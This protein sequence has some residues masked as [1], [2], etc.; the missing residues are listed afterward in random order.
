MTDYESDLPFELQ[1]LLD[2][3]LDK[4]DQVLRS[5]G[6][7]RTDRNAIVDEL[8]NQIMEMLTARTRD[9]GGG[10]G[11]EPSIDDLKA[12]LA[13]IDPPEAYGEESQ[14]LKEDRQESEPAGRWGRL[15]GMLWPVNAA[16]P[17]GL[18]LIS[19]VLVIAATLLADL[20]ESRDFWVLAFYFA[21][22]L[23]L[24]G[25]A[26][27]WPMRRQKKAYYGMWA[28]AVTCVILLLQVA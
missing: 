9:S 24:A 15:A 10:A 26:I 18:C 2:A 22:M 28:N 16:W 11:R 7:S 8:A 20:T 17:L 27:G 4:V 13:E 6:K 25:I 21:I 5:Y 12:V 23:N 19:W 3:H 14:A 1:N